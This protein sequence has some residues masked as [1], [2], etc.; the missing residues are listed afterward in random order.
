MSGVG[1]SGPS[2]TEFS[3]A[4]RVL[5]GPR[6]QLLDALKDV[7]QSG[8]TIAATLRELS[9]LAALGFLEIIE[10]PP[11]PENALRVEGLL[12]ASVAAAAE[13]NVPRALAEL[14]KFAELDP[15]RAETLKSEPGLA[16][17]RNEVG[18]LLFRLAST[19]RLDAES[20]LAQAT[21]LLATAGAK[22]WMGHELRLDSAVL[23]A[24]RLL[25]AGGYANCVY[26]T[27]LSQMAI[28]Q[29]GASAGQGRAPVSSA[30][31]E[32]V[33]SKWL[34]RI[35]KLWA[36]APLLVLLLGWLAVGFVA[37]S[38]YAILRM[39]GPSNELEPSVS[40]GFEIWG[41]GFLALVG[42]GFYAKVRDLVNHRA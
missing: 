30:V 31:G 10:R 39:Y 24:G 35:K 13:G 21:Q 12:S 33:Q 36:R 7:A 2:L 20:R 41:V 3:S 40:W 6:A 38:I 22:E 15:R 32:S 25:E 16:A 19:A 29:L 37:G 11:S 42:L 1:A 26:S 27:A 9:D 14:T 18:E 5:V 28:V 8:D 23:I 34:P 4:L 17:I